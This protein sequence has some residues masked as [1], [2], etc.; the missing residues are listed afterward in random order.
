[1]NTAVTH[2]VWFRCVD[3]F[4]TGLFDG[5][6]TSFLTGEEFFLNPWGKKA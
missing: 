1:M 4:T 3:Y 5:D 2:A 6:D